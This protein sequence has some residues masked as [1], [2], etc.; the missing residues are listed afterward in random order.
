MTSA[1][2]CFEEIEVGHRFPPITTPPLTTSHLVRW[3]GASENWHKIHYDATFAK[4]HDGL[5]GLLINGSLKQ[6]FL[7]TA[8][9]RWAGPQGW[10]WKLSFQFRAMNVVGETLTVWGRVD[11]VESRRRFGI[12]HLEIGI[13]NEAGMESTP[14]HA[15]LV[16]PFRGGP[17][18]PYPFEPT[19]DLQ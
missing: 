8:L 13:R 11:Q 12:A 19:R 14:G 6:H 1:A 3:C 4:D 18:V 15:S 10:L 7:A 5:P 16:L 17:A 9:K 2:V